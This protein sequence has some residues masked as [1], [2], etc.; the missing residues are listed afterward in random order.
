MKAL[1]KTEPGPGNVKLSEVNEPIPGFGQVKIAVK[2]CG[3]CGTD[4]KIEKDL[5]P[6]KPPVILGHEF[7]GI[8]HEIGEGVN[9]FKKGDRVVSETMAF[10]CGSCKYCYTGNYMMC[11]N[12]LSAGYGVDG[13]FAEFCVIREGALHKL[14]D[15]VSFEQGALAEPLAVC[16]HFVIE[17]SNLKLGEFVLVSGA[18]TIGLLAA[19]VAKT[20]G[21][22]VILAGTSCDIERLKI[23]KEMGADR[24]MNIEEEDLSSVIKEI[25]AGY[26]VDKAFECA[27]TAT[28]V[29]NCIQSLR[30][31]GTLTQVGLNEK[32]VPTDF[33]QISRKEL[34]IIGSFGHNWANWET[35]IHLLKNFGDVISKVISDIRPLEDWMEAFKEMENRTAIKILLYPHRF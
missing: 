11:D 32:L 9:N 18:G 35:S 19:F 24:V 13:G 30:K 3:I 16:I 25:T 20:A 14:P 29:Q 15:N 31:R 1:V 6:S 27:G 23:G 4:L 10:S 28:S 8:V 2:Y 33:N 17:L 22:Y 5:A 21:A 26:G 7:C 34:R 12:R